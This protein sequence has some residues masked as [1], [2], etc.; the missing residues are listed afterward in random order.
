MRKIDNICNCQEGEGNGHF[1]FV[2]I[3]FFFEGH[4]GNNLSTL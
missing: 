3:Y 4:F 1:I 2:E